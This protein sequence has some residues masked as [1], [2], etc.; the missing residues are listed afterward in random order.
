M[1]GT[2]Q[3]GER[4]DQYRCIAFP[5]I[6]SPTAYV[7]CRTIPF[8]IEPERGRGGAC[9]WRRDH[10]V[11]GVTERKPETFGSYFVL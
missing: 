9:Q 4:R 8:L 10:T 3:E 11:K 6:Q 7:G 5:E 2:V 1:Q